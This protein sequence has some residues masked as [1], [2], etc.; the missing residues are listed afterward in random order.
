MKYSLYSRYK[1]YNLFKF[2][3]CFKFSVETNSMNTLEQVLEIALKRDEFRSY[4]HIIKQ[5]LN[6]I[7]VDR[8]HHNDLIW[9][10]FL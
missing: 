5:L 3:S 4:P 10:V 8:V 2:T 9:F 7:A 6:F 1:R